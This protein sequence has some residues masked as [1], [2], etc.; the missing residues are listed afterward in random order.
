VAVTLAFLAACAFAVGTVLQQKGTL[1]P[2]AGENDPR[3]LIQ[4]IRRPVW[5]AGGCVLAVGWVL[6]ATASGRAQLEVVQSV[7]SLSLVI[8]L[9]LGARITNQDIT[10]RVRHGAEIMVVGVVLF[11]VAS[12]GPGGG[13]SPSASAWWSTAAVAAGAVTVLGVLA[14]SRHGATRALLLG[15]A[16]AVVGLA[17]AITGIGLVA[18]AT[19]STGPAA[20]DGD[21]VAEDGTTTPPARP[22]RE[23]GPR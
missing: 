13:S 12:G 17:L 23:A 16:A 18:E 6:Q 11:T 2:P 3:F 20:P 21:A 4:V 19:T 5:L 1:E 14:L 7:S 8:A 15:S 9:P 22:H 10:S